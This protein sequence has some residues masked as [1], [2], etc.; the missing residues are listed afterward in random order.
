[1]ASNLPS[2]FS[3]G[4][5]SAAAQAPHPPAQSPPAQPQ[6]AGPSV[7]DNLPMLLAVIALALGL[8]ATYGAFFTDRPLSLAQKEELAGIAD[9]L[10]SLQ[11]RPIQMSAPMQGTVYINQSYPVSDMFPATFD[12]PLSFSIPI[13][14]QLIAVSTTGQPVAFRVQENVPI[15]VDIPIQ[16]ATAFGNNTV[17]I[18]KDIP[19]DA[20]WSSNINVRAAYGQD[21]N[22]IIDDL[23]AMAGN[24]SG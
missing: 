21:L 13:D 16:S 15:K 5:T 12:M 14:T 18:Q 3:R 20:V 6:Q 10:R 4:A 24:V 9:G 1:M 8:L 23:D 2:S 19:I 22:G 7:R 11:G 17:T